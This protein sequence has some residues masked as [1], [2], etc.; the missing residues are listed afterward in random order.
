[1]IVEIRHTAAKL[2]HRCIAPPLLHSFT[3]CSEVKRVARPP[4]SS[5]QML[6][7][8]NRSFR[9][10]ASR[11]Q[12]RIDVAA[13]AAALYRLAAAWPY[14]GA[15]L[16]ATHLLP[17]AGCCCFSA[18]RLACS[19]ISASAASICCRLRGAGV[20]QTARPAGQGR[21]RAQHSVINFDQLEQRGW[22]LH[23]APAPHRLAAA[24]QSTAPCPRRMPASARVG[25][26][27]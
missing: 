1:M 5:A 13:A 16:V 26:R 6:C 18:M 11:K 15:P 9:S 19:T 2:R 20:L 27:K 25:G 17:P 14:W 24:A 21:A 3:C 22:H 7:R 12:R 10:A 4:T 23:L 8:S